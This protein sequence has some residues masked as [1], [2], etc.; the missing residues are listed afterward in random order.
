MSERTVTSVKVGPK[1]QIVIPADTRKMFGINPG[2]TLLFFTDPENGMALRK[3]ECADELIRN[4]T[5]SGDDGYREFA[6]ET[7]RAR[8][9][10]RGEEKGDE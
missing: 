10:V 5:S 2:D 4:V 1:G 7:V 6:A 9:A 8:E 3:M